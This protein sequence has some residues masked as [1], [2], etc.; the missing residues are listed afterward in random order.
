M[1]NE[2]ST[3]RNVT[4][5]ECPLPLGSPKEIQIGHGGGGRLSQQLIDT[6]FIPAFSNPA[7]KAA[8]DGAVIASPSGSLAFST[9]S[10][11]V[12]PIE[13]PGG[14]IGSLAIHGTANDLAM[15]GAKPRWMSA[16]FI[17]EEGLP[18]AQ[19]REIVAS[20]RHAADEVGIQ[21]V[22]GDTKVVE[23]GK[24][25]SIYINTAGIGE[26][27]ASKPIGPATV[28]EGDAILL[29]GDIGRHGM[30]IMAHREG[31]EFE[32]TIE[33]DSAHLWPAVEALIEAQLD[34]HCLRDLTRGG[35][36]AAMH[37]ISTASGH[38]FLLDEASISVDEAVLG[39]CEL[40]GLDALHVANE[41]RFAVILPGA[42]AEKALAILKAHA[43][44]GNSASIIGTVGPND[45]GTVLLKS[46][47]GV[48]R[49][50]DRP[51]GEQLP[52]IC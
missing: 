38:E 44:G 10:H 45:R 3:P 51:S 30:A 4:S 32:T 41:G 36:A 16:G 37:E 13:F 28:R 42:E 12:R 49:I 29:S 47:I 20:M 50:L 26:M 22:T 35:L 9:D 18:I 5:F 31:L 33:S 19:L 40:L 6:L 27:Q 52:R 23:R 39:A 11:V 25:D 46:L 34:L 48:E 15:C 17:L 7:L 21:I 1:P 24:G 14:N 43:P 2:E 8:H